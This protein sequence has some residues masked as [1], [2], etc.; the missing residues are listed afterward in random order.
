M[1]NV[2]SNIDFWC[3]GIDD[4][5]DATNPN[6]TLLD[7]I[8]S[9]NRTRLKGLISWISYHIGRLCESWRTGALNL[10][11]GS[12]QF[13]SGRPDQKNQVFT[14]R[15]FPLKSAFSILSTK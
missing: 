9:T 5:I 8:A 10:G 7:E 3:P 12:P 4:L 13:K 6:Q 14:E 2:E 15:W 11:A 1:Q